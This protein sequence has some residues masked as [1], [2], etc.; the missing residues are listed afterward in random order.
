MYR[1]VLFAV[2][3]IIAFCTS[4]KKENAQVKNPEIIG[5]GASFDLEKI[6][7]NENVPLLFSKCLSYWLSDS[8][9]NVDTENLAYFPY[10]TTQFTIPVHCDQFG[11]IYESCI[12][13]S[14]AVFDSLNFRTVK[15]V[16]N[17][18][19]AMIAVYAETE[20][21]GRMNVK[22]FLRRIVQKYGDCS[23]AYFLDNHY[24]VYSYEWDLTD[25]VLQIRTSKGFSIT[26]ST[27]EEGWKQ[28]EYTKCE[29][30]IIKKGEAEK[31]AESKR[32][33]IEGY[34]EM[35]LKDDF[36]LTS[37]QLRITK[38]PDIEMLR[39]DPKSLRN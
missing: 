36:T 14:L 7:F 33:K 15:I 22:D 23:E 10:D 34:D 4:C 28:D 6:T 5:Q 3:F 21:P 16:T 8:E 20:L 29:V 24:D 2:I 19:T 39:I 26:A 17:M 38:R 27:N 13:D 25:R 35:F 9:G 32:L 31:I 30:L 12:K 18:D 1:F 37:L 11:Y